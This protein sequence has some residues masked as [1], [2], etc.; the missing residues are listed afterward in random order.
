MKQMS[1]AVTYLRNTRR[2][3]L[4][5]EIQISTIESRSLEKFD[6]ELRHFFSDLFPKLK[7]KLFSD[8]FSQNIAPY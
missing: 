4:S 7:K 5:F 8:M 6:F 1:N 2:F 3:L